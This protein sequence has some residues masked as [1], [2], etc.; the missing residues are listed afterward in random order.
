MEGTAF[1]YI[2]LFISFLKATGITFFRSEVCPRCGLNDIK[3]FKK[4]S[5][6]IDYDN[7]STEEEIYSDAEV[8][9]VEKEIV[10]PDE[11]SELMQQL[12]DD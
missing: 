12:K 8:P 2:I 9:E 11:L 4:Q 5:R 7:D 3:T 1:L 6:T 10:C